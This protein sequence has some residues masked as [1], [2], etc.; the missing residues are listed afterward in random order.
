MNYTHTHTF[1]D[2]LNR[3]HFHLFC[4]FTF[5]DRSKFSAMCDELGIDQPEW[6]EFV[7]LEDSS[8]GKEGKRWDLQFSWIF[9]LPPKRCDFQMSLPCCAFVSDRRDALLELLRRKLWALPIW[10]ASLCWCVLHMSCPV[11]PC[12]SLIMRT[13]MKGKRDV[14]FGDFVFFVCR[15]TNFRW[16]RAQFCKRQALWCV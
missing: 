6:S 5:E 10:W 1:L 7:K 16:L 4:H 8:K 3:N 2:V 12:A 11:Q 9:F 14:K 13:D 15:V